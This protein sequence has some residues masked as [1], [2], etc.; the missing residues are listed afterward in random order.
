MHSAKYNK[1]PRGKIFS[2]KLRSEEFWVIILTLIFSYK[3]EML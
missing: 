1:Y 2:S 3:G